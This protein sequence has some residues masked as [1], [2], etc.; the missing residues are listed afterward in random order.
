MLRRKEQDYRDKGKIISRHM[1]KEYAEFQNI[2]RT[3]K[4][5]VQAN[6]GREAKGFLLSPFFDKQSLHLCRLMSSWQ[7]MVRFSKDPSQEGKWGWGQGD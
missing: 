6:S 7:A 4:F 3:C 1:L 5:D 2:N